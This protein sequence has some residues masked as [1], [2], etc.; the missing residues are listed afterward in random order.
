M[1][2]DEIVAP[3]VSVCI[4]T[5]NMA[6]FVGSALES[7]LA[8]TYPSLEILVS[9]NASSDETAAVLSKY[10]DSRLT[11]SQNSVN[12][13]PVGNFNKL[14]LGSRGE[15]IKFLEADDLL[16]PECVSEMLT[17]AT[18]YASV[19]IVSSP[20]IIIGPSGEY[21]GNPYKGKARVVRGSDILRESRN[22]INEIGT[23][24][25]VLVRRETL[26]AAGLFDEEFGAYLNDFDLW[27]RC[28]EMCD[29]SFLDRPLVKVRRH[30][31]QIGSWGSIN[32]ADIDAN[33]LMVRKR[34]GSAPVLSSRWFTEAMFA[35]SL[36]EGYL[37]RGFYRAARNIHREGGASRWVFVKKLRANLGL[38]Q[39]CIMLA[40]CVMRS[41]VV[42][43]LKLHERVEA[44]RQAKMS[45]AMLSA[46]G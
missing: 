16:E 37:W 24:T 41:P 45:G 29:V 2:A 15:W 22:S 31:G 13:G 7:A 26:I 17:A 21:L 30:P 9:D 3:L 11:I 14:I 1:H 44:K 19:G 40:C 23:P 28:I 32:N 36:S 34:F 12:L 46:A 39:L 20:R 42:M 27:L 8:Q 25:D 4:P 6:R 18:S 43:F 5:Y 35:L 10:R 38:A 33:F